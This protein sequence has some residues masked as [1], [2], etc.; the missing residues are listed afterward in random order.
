MRTQILTGLR[1]H[2]IIERV[3]KTQRYRLTAFGLKTALFY[4]R[5]Y[6]RLL[7]PALSE[8]HAPP[9]TESPPLAAAFATFQ[10]ALDRY[11]IDRIAV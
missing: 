8:L 1:L 11:S 6:Q 9:Q 2:A 7:R 5:V 3:P 10:T 4:S